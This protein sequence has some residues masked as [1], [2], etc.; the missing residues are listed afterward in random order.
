MPL[1]LTFPQHESCAI[2]LSA[3]TRERQCGRICIG[4][5]FRD[6]TALP[7]LPKRSQRDGN[8]SAVISG[9]IR[10]GMLPRQIRFPGQNDHAARVYGKFLL[11]HNCSPAVQLFFP[12]EPEHPLFA[13]RD[14][15]NRT[16]VEQLPCIVMMRTNVVPKLPRVPVH[17]QTIQSA[18]D[19]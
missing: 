11:V 12:R 15:R 19:C 3:S 13:Q 18:I 7:F 1:V 9:K 2:Q 17:Q 14:R 10:D 5:H 16:A 4:L 6:P 8:T